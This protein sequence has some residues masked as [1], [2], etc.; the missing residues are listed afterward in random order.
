[1]ALTIKPSTT[2]ASITKTGLDAEK[3][4]GLVAFQMSKKV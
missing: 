3:L 4:E 1:M 2:E